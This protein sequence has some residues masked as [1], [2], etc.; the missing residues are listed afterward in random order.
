MN[1]N[2]NIIIMMILAVII[3]LLG[4]NTNKIL[5]LSN[6]EYNLILGCTVIVIVSSILIKLGILKHKDITNES[7]TTDKLQVLE[8][9]EDK[10]LRCLKISMINKDLLSDTELFKGIHNTIINLE[11]FI[12]FSYNKIII[13]SV[14]LM[15]EKEHSLH[16]N[17]YINNDTTFEQY[18]DTIKMN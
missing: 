1:K 11:E 7:E 17:I 16:S 4:N 13:L 6:I 2:I 10:N 18:Y 15:S 3:F 14:V 9:N 8:I 12:N 5:D